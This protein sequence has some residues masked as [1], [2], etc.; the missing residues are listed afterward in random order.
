MAFAGDS[1]TVLLRSD[2]QAV[3][4]GSNPDGQNECGI[5]SL[6]HPNRPRKV[7]GGH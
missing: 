3:A 6:C 4:C 2:G 5:P 1:H 7:S